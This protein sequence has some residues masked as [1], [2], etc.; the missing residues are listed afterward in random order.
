MHQQVVDAILR[1][2]HPLLENQFLFNGG[3]P[4]AL[5]AI[6]AAISAGNHYSCE[7]DFVGFYGSVVVDD[8][9]EVTRPLP[10]SISQHVVW[11]EH[12]RFNDHLFVTLSSLRSDPTP[13]PPSGLYLGSASSPIVGEILISR[14]LADAQLG[15]I[16]TYADNLCVLGRSEEEVTAR[17]TSLRDAINASPLRCVSGLRVTHKPIRNVFEG[18]PS[19]SGVEFS[20]H[21]AITRRNRETASI[22]VSGWQPTFDKIAQYQIGAAEYVSVDDLNTAIT[23]VS[24]WKR[25]YSSWPDGDLFEAEYLAWLKARRFLE[26]GTPEHKASAIAA[27]V[28]AHLMHDSGERGDLRYRDFLPGLRTVAETELDQAIQERLNIILNSRTRQRSTPTIQDW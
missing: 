6:E 2:L 27:V 26:R 8:L 22:R 25:Y 17:I 9:A 1:N 23:K 28:N 3:M 11:D 21:R 20:S 4:K 7:L 12:L 18:K 13:E 16:I 10:N 19:V 15:D 24:N 5:S 14:L